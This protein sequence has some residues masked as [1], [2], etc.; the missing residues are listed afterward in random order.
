MTYHEL[1]KGK[2]MGELEK[3]VMVIKEVRNYLLPNH[4]KLF[5]SSPCLELS[6]HFATYKFESKA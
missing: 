4:S 6:Q 2:F 3:Q 1:Y 5:S